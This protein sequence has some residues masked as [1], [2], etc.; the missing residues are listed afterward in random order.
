MIERLRDF[1]ILRRHPRSRVFSLYMDSDLDARRRRTL[2]AHIRDCFRCRRE[3]ASL[4]NTVRA[5][6][7]L[8]PDSPM[9]LADSIIAALGAEDPPSTAISSPAS[10]AVGQ[11]VLTVVA[12]SAPRAA[13][14]RSGIRWRREARSALRWCLQRPQLRL[15]LP[16]AVVAGVVLSLANMGGM[17]MHG[18]IDLGVCVSC[19]I[20][21]LVPFLALNL[22]LLMLLWVPRRRRP[23][24]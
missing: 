15:T 16:I 6:G 14:E 13:G 9:G 5:L 4:A 11:P 21:F 24:A 22:G 2:E 7:S 18:R 3:L 23:L 10:D 17:L 20:D 19:A 1:S 8:A 12:S